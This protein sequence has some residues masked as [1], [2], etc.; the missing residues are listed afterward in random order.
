M[1]AILLLSVVLAQEALANFS[2]PDLTRPYGTG[3]MRDRDWDWA[4]STFG[5]EHGPRDND[6][7]G[8]GWWDRY[9]V[10][11][12]HEVIN[13]K[14]IVTEEHSRE[15]S[16]NFSNLLGSSFEKAV[17]S[18]WVNGPKKG[19]EEVS[20]WADGTQIFTSELSRRQ[21]NY[22]ID[23]LKIAPQSL[24]DGELTLKFL[25]PEGDYF[26]RRIALDIRAKEPDVAP[27][28]IPGSVWLLGSGILGTLVANSGLGTH[29]IRRFK[30]Q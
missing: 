8:H 17:L 30:K 18:F 12:F 22:R 16:F 6:W 28:P 27:V 2:D 14:F 19:S 24:K 9:P 3:H 29:L 26:V 5:N 15:F 7:F 20:L 4:F 11:R 10:E 13:G 23:L 25:A 1:V 21:M